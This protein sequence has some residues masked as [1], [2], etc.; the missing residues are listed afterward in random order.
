MTLETAHQSLGNHNL[1][2]CNEILHM[3]GGRGGFP[4]E[5]AT[6]TKRETQSEA[7]RES[8]R[9]ENISMRLLCAWLGLRHSLRMSQIAESQQIREKKHAQH[10]HQN[11]DH[12]ITDHTHHKITP[13]NEKNIKYHAYRAKWLEDVVRICRGHGDT[14]ETESEGMDFFIKVT[15]NHKIELDMLE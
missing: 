6:R 1:R 13:M 12:C 8:E 3:T 11:T 10:H 14:V 4:C 15:C 5:C 7:G 9:S 2:L